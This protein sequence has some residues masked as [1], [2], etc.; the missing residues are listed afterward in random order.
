MINIAQNL[1]RLPRRR[2]LLHTFDD[3]RATILGDDRRGDDYNDDESLQHNTHKILFLALC[4]KLFLV[5]CVRRRRP[6]TTARRR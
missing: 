4:S 5:N 3:F 1:F 6:P 2:L